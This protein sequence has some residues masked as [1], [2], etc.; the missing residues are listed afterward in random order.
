MA[1]DQ[2]LSSHS[3]LPFRSCTVRARAKTTLKKGAV[4]TAIATSFTVTYLKLLTLSLDPGL[5][6]IST[7]GILA[8]FHLVYIFTIGTCFVTANLER[9]V[10]LVEGKSSL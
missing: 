7:M 1:S 4:R 3:S 5:G 6:S 2:C 10:D 9:I 8:N